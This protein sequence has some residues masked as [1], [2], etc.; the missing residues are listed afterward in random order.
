[1]GEVIVCSLVCGYVRE[2]GWG[3]RAKSVPKVTQGRESTG[4]TVGKC[5]RKN[6]RNRAVCPKLNVCVFNVM[7]GLSL[8][9]YLGRQS[10][11]LVN[12]CIW[13]NEVASFLCMACWSRMYVQMRVL[14]TI[15]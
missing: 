4:A 3:G 6:A 10:C 13:R 2:W 9:A 5:A 8:Y 12:K 14:K 1:M 15:K 11:A 7:Y